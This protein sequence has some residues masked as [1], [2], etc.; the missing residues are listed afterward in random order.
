MKLS[1]Y[2]E[3]YQKLATPEDID[4]LAENFGY[5]KELLLVVH[6]QRIV[7]ETTRKFYRV[8]AQA[9]RLAWMWQNGSTIVDI[10][11][12]F[13][14]PPI[15]TALMIL[16]QRKIS[17][18]QFWKMIGDLESVKDRRLRRDLDETVRADIIYSPEGTARQY[19]RGRWGEAKLHTWLDARALAY[20]TEKQ[21]R[22][23]YDK[24][25]DILLHNPLDM[26]GTRKYWIESKA[27]FGD[28]YEIKRHI[29]KQ[30]GP[31]SELFGDGAIVYWFGH[32]DDVKYDLPEGVDIVDASFFEPTPV[33]YD[34]VPVNAMRV[35]PAA[36][37]GAEVDLSG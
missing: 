30:M 15:L 34:Y 10:A 13:E 32:V 5:D 22:A 23:K 26:N 31:Y 1:E 2:Q 14:F 18:K 36:L 4:F 6:T 11:R 28:P 9:R 19:A 33:P 8:K 37:R 21:L 35:D 7:R 3:L 20:E 29:R 24:T 17:R 27:T 25:P 16:E 12:K